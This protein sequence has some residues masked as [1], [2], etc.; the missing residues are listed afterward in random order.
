MHNSGRW[1]EA[2]PI[3]CMPQHLSATAAVSR[4]E[5]LKGSVGDC[6]GRLCARSFKRRRRRPTERPMP[7]LALDGHVRGF[8]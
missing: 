4:G 2:D 7:R 5:G 3:S 1:F 8:I 6:R